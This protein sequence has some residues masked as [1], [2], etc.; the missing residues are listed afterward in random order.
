MHCIN[1]HLS[2]GCIENALYAGHLSCAPS[3]ERES[4]GREVAGCGRPCPRNS[5]PNPL[6][7]GLGTPGGAPP[8]ASG[9]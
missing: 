1:I 6:S 5:Y 2:P 7:G 3:E 9:S 4:Q 8:P